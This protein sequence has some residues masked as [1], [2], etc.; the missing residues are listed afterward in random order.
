MINKDIDIS[1]T[2]LELSDNEGTAYLHI[3]NKT[4]SS[5]IS[6]AMDNV[7][8]DGREDAY[9]YFYVNG[10]ETA[11]AAAD[12]AFAAASVKEV[13]IKEQELYNADGIVITLPEQKLDPSKE[14]LIHF[15]NNTETTIYLSYMNLTVDGEL[16]QEGAH[17]TADGGGYAGA[18]A[19][20]EIPV[21]ESLQEA[22]NSGR[23]S[24]EISFVLF[25]TE[26]Q[27]DPLGEAA[28][29]IPYTIT[30]E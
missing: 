23:E 19:D 5:T 9:V 18:S 30:A 27:R 29:T 17:N 2:N 14:P 1:L 22:V 4:E 24:G 10:D 13:Y 11:A 26:N 15:E 7:K 25:L 12:K 6:I 28:V 8:I 3:I 21:G 20:E 16:I